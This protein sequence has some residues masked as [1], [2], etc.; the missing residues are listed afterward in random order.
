MTH[1]QVRAAARGTGRAALVVVPLAFLGVLFA[2]PVA[3]IIGR[4]LRPGGHWQLGQG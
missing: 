2:Y 1:P 3:A 4:G